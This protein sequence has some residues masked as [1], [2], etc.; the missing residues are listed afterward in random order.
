M[1]IIFFSFFFWRGGWYFFSFSC[2]NLLYSRISSIQD[3]KES[4]PI[5]RT[6]V[7]RLFHESL[8]DFSY[9][10]T[11]FMADFQWATFLSSTSS[12]RTRYV[13][14]AESTH[15]HSLPILLE[16]STFHSD[17]FVPKLLRSKRNFWK[18]SSPGHYNL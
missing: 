9:F 10:I 16:R 12:D 4:L 13:A 1:Y 3:P 2:H 18:V 17:S 5:L 8:L 7:K 14:C 11:I 15:L 6:G